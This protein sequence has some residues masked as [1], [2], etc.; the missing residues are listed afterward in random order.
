M[1]DNIS[2]IRTVPI[3]AFNLTRRFGTQKK[4]ISQTNALAYFSVTSTTEYI[5]LARLTG[6]L[7]TA[8]FLLYHNKLERLSHPLT[9]SKSN[10]CEQG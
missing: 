2:L 7:V 1:T 4:F 5:S 3:S 8:V 6:S 10:I 9:P